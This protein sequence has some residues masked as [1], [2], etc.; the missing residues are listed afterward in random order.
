M[1]NVNLCRHC[2]H[3]TYKMRGYYVEHTA[4]VK[5]FLVCY[6]KGEYC[7]EEIKPLEED[8]AE[9]CKYYEEGKKR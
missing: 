1:S 8:R 5:P 9:T 4:L 3:S 6:Q 2:K 7:W